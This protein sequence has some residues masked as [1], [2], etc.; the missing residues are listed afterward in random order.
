MQYHPHGDA[1]IDDALVVLANKRYLIEGQGNFGNIFTGD[2][3]AAPRYIE[4]R[5]TELARTEL[6]NDEITDFVPSLRWPQ[7]GAGDAA[8]QTAAD[9]HAR[10]GRHRRRDGARAF[11]RTIFPNCSKRRLPFSKSS[12]SSACRIFRPAA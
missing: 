1:S 3:A 2:P 4:C 6:F 8:L 5:L 7:P 11:C 10:H 9:A 12:R